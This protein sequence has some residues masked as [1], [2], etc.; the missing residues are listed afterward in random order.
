MRK[1][2]INGAEL[3]IDTIG[4]PDDPAILLIHGA[5]ASM[6]RWEDSFCA[7]L[8]QAGRYVIRYDHR[9]TGRST[10]YEPGKPPYT[11]DDLVTDAVGILDTLN[12]ERAHV[13]GMSMGG[14]IAQHIA[15]RH[16]QRVRS[17]T[18]MSTSPATTGGPSLPPS[19]PGLFEDQPP[20]PD[21]HDRDATIAHLREAERPYA[22]SRGLRRARARTAPRPRLR[23][24]DQPR[25]RR[26]PLRDRPGRRRSSMGR[27]RMHRRPHARHPRLRRPPLPTRPRRGPGRPDPGREAADPRR[28][29]PRVPALGP[30]RSPP[31]ADRQHPLAVSPARDRI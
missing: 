19:A 13:V 26:Q 7:R 1:E 8:A 20:E 6:D 4:D 17:L 10:T 29:R 11:G 28:H 24:H 3:C 30:R 5:G 15:I 27:A 9:D 16:S 14:G 22:G 21:W 2:K 12:I 31:C 25:E 18:L 23:P